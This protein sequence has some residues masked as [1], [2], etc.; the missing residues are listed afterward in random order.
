MSYDIADAKRP[1]GDALSSG[2]DAEQKREVL[3]LSTELTQV[4]VLEAK[5]G[6]GTVRK[7]NS[8]TSWQRAAPWACSRRTPIRRD[9]RTA[10]PGAPVGPLPH[11]R[12]LTGPTRGSPRSSG[13]LPTT[14]SPT[15]TRAMFGARRSIS[16][17]FHFGTIMTMSGSGCTAGASWTSCRSSPGNQYLQADLLEGALRRR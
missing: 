8:S 15:S 14:S 16:W 3:D 12:R 17:T 6:Q 11:G 2:L 1:P 13:A 10:G 5:T 9:A 4:P 7:S